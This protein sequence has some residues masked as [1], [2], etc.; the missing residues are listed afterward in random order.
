MDLKMGSLL[1]LV[2]KPHKK[3]TSKILL[4]NF[5]SSRDGPEKG[6][7]K[8]EVKTYQK[9]LLHYKMVAEKQD[10]KTTLYLPYTFLYM[11]QIW[12]SL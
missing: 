7:K 10:K 9:N 3:G 2:Y 8:T 6:I 4:Q 11:Q 12:G 5:I 1:K